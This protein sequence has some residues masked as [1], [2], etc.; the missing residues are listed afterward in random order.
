MTA[1]NQTGRCALVARPI[2]YLPS[3]LEH[4]ADEQKMLMCVVPGDEEHMV[5]WKNCKVPLKSQSFTVN[6]GIALAGGCW[7]CGNKRELYYDHVMGFVCYEK[8]ETEAKRKERLDKITTSIAD[9][10]EPV[11]EQIRKGELTKKRFEKKKK[12]NKK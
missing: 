6:T 12:G 2:P 1:N 3:P 8:D 9:Q 5:R 4:A 10:I 7:I 11:L